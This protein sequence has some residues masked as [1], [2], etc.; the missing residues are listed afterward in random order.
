MIVWKIN[1]SSSDARVTETAVTK[2]YN[3]LVLAA[4]DGDLTALCLLNLTNVLDT[5]DHD[6]NVSLA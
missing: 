6:W 4:D 5:V 3:D 2:V 1:S